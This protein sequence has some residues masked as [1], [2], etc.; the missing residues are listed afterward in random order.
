MKLID[1]GSLAAAL[2]AIV[3]A[4]IAHAQ[5]YPTKPVRLIV[6]YSPGGGSD[7]T[8][9]AV[10]QK[11]TEALGETF[12]VD[13]R[14]GMASMIGTEIAARAASDGYTLLLADAAHSINAVVYA[15]PRYDAIK[16]FA[17]I[18][19][20]ATTPLALMAHP[21]F[22]WTATADSIFAKVQRLCERISG[23]A[24]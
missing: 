4:P 22:A 19:L 15:K 24:H 3:I 2:V 12:V 17:P 14:P 21:S 10:G 13:T 18:S 1:I 20:I 11:L 23:T 9:R 7:I 16:S 8:A 6:P 5:R